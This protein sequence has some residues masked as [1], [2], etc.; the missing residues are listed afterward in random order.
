MTPERQIQILERRL[1]LQRKYWLRAAKKALDGDVRELRTRVE[2]E[3]AEPLQ[4]VL[5]QNFEPTS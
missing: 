4:I 3:E 5:S 1:D 2:M